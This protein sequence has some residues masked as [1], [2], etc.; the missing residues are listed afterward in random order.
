VVYAIEE[1]TADQHVIR[2]QQDNRMTVLDR[3]VADAAHEEILQQ[4]AIPGD[5]RL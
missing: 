2:F 5:R 3:K 4:Y 1:N